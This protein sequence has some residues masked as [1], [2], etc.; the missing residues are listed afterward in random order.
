MVYKKTPKFSIRSV[1]DI[2]KD[3]RYAKE[4]LGDVRTVFFPAG[5]TIIMKTDDLTEICRYARVL[6]PNLERITIYASSQ[7]ICRKGEKGMKQLAKAGL[8]RV[9][10]GLETGDDVILKRIKKGSTSKDHV[11]AGRLTKE[12]GIELNSYVMLG[13]GG[14]ERTREHV[15]ATVYVLNEI[16]PDCIRLRTFLPKIGTP[17]F[18][19]IEKGDFQVLSAHEVL[20]ETRS[21]IEGLEV[22]SQIVSDHYT[23]Y[24]D[25]HGKL[26]DGR[27]AMLEEVDRALER[28]ESS[29]R[30]VYIGRQ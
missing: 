9:H 19:E 23:N 3:L 26:P 7:Y 8:S 6:F 25:V 5:N 20:Q 21:L 18:E 2:K 12:A 13:I 11:T 29:Y 24:I 4:F 10:V 22:T 14:N 28:D 30:S 17:I 1:G 27:K 15:E 16:D